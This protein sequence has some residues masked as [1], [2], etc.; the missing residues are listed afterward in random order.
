VT[1]A[2]ELPPADAGPNDR[3][4]PIAITGSALHGLLESPSTRIRGLV[5]IADVAP[6]ALALAGSPI[7]ATVAGR[8][9][10][11]AAEPD[12]LGRLASLDASLE[13]VRDARLPAGLAYA[14]L[15]AALA[16]AALLRRTPALGRAAV[17]V[18]PAAAGAST[19][20]GLARVE[21][22][23]PFV[24]VTCALVAALAATGRTRTRLGLVLVLLLG[25]QLAVLAADRE[26]VSL[27][28]LGPNPDAGGR[29][30]GLPN[31][32]ET[33]LVA[34]TIT[35]AALV[36]PRLRLTGLA[37]VCA[38][39]L[40]TIGAGRL[41]AAV[42]GAIAL[43]AGSAV[44][45]LDLARRRALPLVAGGAAAAAALLVL[46]GPAHLANASAGS[47]ADRVE[48]SARLA[49][50]GW[51]QGV[52]VFAVGLV[53]L[54][55]LAIGY[56][57]L[58]RRLAVPERAALLALLAALP[59]SLVLNDSPGAVLAHGTLACAGLVALGATE[60]PARGVV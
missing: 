13:R 3:R 12:P 55:G 36:W 40:V 23:W 25:L 53:P 34:Q 59:V 31:E 5:S 42:V 46:A 24:L 21:S 51:E 60:R 10:G 16:A 37:A 7:P 39:G 4:Y 54:A 19:L 44:L 6:T 58:R 11:A 20:L 32:L 1:S 56:P 41:G 50:S 52:L 35:A 26:A 17:L 18:L 43:A 30:Y 15:A 22:W 47:V 49:V 38:L 57:R 48:L 8:R 33:I 9:L 28:L 27:S 14:V 2:L 45:A 29:F